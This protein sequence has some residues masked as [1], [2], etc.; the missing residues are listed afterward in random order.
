MLTAKPS[1]PLGPITISNVEESSADIEWEAPEQDG[2]APIKKYQIE[3]RPANRSTWTKAGTVDGNTYKFNVKDLKE[4]QDYYFRVTAIN[5]EGSGS[6]L[7]SADMAKPRKIIG[8][9]IAYI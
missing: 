6:P 7:E 4:G 9:F 5:S 1:A 8:R 3:Y 2:G